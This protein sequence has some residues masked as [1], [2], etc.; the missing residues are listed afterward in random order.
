MPDIPLKT[1][2]NLY[3][4]SVLEEIMLVELVNRHADGYQRMA[5]GTPHPDR[6]TYPG[7][8]LADEKP[9]EGTEDMVRRFWASEEK[10]PDTIN[11]AIEYAL[12]SDTHPIWARRYRVRRDQYVVAAYGS[13]FSGVWLIRVT[14]GGSG[15][16]TPPAVTLSGGGGSGAT[17]IAII[18]P[19]L[20]TVAWVR[21][22]AE[23]TGYTSA[24][25]VAFAGGSGG[26]GATAVAVMQGTAKLV[27]QE[28]QPLPAEDPRSSVW[29]NVLRVWETIPGSELIGR[30]VDTNRGRVV[31]VYDQVVDAGTD[32]VKTDGVTAASVTAID[33]NKSK[34]RTEVNVELVTLTGAGA[35]S[36]VGWLT[37]QDPRTHADIYTITALADKGMTLPAIDLEIILDGDPLVIVSREKKGFSE[38]EDEWTIKAV[39]SDLADMSYVEYGL[40][41]IR[42]PGIYQF[43]EQFVVAFTFPYRPPFPG[44]HYNYLAPRTNTVPARQTHYFVRGLPDTIPQKFTVVSPGTESKMV[45]IREDTIH[46]PFQWYVNDGDD[47]F[48]TLVEN[49]PASSPASYDP[50]DIYV[51][52]VEAKRWAGDIYE[53]IVTEASE[54]QSI[55]YFPPAQ[56]GTGFTIGPFGGGLAEADY[57]TSG[58]FAVNT[59]AGANNIRLFGFQGPTWKQINGTLPVDAGLVNLGESVL[60]TLEYI[61]GDGTSQA[62]GVSIYTYGTA[63]S[64]TITFSSNPIDGDQIRLG[65]LNG[66]AT[67]NTTYTFKTTL[68]ENILA[69]GTLTLVANPSDGDTVTIGPAGD[70]QTWMFKTTLSE[71][72]KATGTLVAAAGPPVGPPNGATVTIGDRTYTASDP[73]VDLPNNVLSD[74]TLGSILDFLDNL[75][76]AINGGAGAGTLYGS[77]TVAHEEVT[78]AS[79]SD[80]MVVTAIDGGTDANSIATSISGSMTGY[81]AWALPYLSGGLAAVADQVFIGVSASASIDN[82]IA[83]I[84]ESGTEGTNYS[85]GTDESDYVTAAAGVGDTMVASS[86]TGGTAAN[87]ITTTETFTNAGNVWGAG[88]LSGGLAA[89]A[90]EVQRGASSAISSFNLQS[91]INGDGAAGVE[92]ST[93]T[94]ANTIIEVPA[95]SLVSASFVVS[96]I[97][98]ADWTAFGSWQTGGNFVWIVDANGAFPV[99]DFGTVGALTGAANGSLLGTLSTA[100]HSLIANLRSFDDQQLKTRNFPP[101]PDD[102]TTSVV[103]VGNREITIMF[104]NFGRMPLKYQKSVDGSTGW[105]DG[106]TDL[107][108]A[109]IYPNMGTIRRVTVTD[110]DGASTYRYIR[111]VIDQ[112]SATI[113]TTHDYGAGRVSRQFIT[114]AWDI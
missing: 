75:T 69:T 82:L 95:G 70:T 15:Y 78:A 104:G 111:F 25:T 107:N 63:G 91:A 97:I 2:W 49:I 47:V 7:V 106:T 22:T 26:S 90:Y 80:D 65:F 23:G 24:P 21:I 14:D 84:N 54:G 58:F 17:A 10:N 60:D 35:N 71:N 18:D 52:D 61:T 1:P 11:Y 34:R 85:T 12:E 43:L 93:G 39:P 99:N 41:A 66:T 59:N 64:S 31:A 5:P 94:V 19:G 6:S 8:I 100:E 83:A 29:V 67:Y 114:V 4:T 62:D 103:G 50:N 30:Y 110:F 74:N 92:Y 102:L 108:A 76:A 33:N 86:L 55:T 28:V 40:V 37:K 38:A 88:T 46:P 48:S 109:P 89:V 68:T 20:K 73:F 57:S 13:T 77:G 72:V 87:S 51:W 16:S 53:V 98:A 79:P 32:I 105:V 27:H 42:F 45:G 112:A 3:P 9:I 56:I 113:P 81:A 36:V 101:T 96:T 44:V